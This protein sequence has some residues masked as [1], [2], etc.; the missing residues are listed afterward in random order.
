MDIY[1][2]FLYRMHK[3]G[4]DTGLVVLMQV[5]DFY[6]TYDKSAGRCQAVLGLKLHEQVKPDKTKHFITGFPKHALNDYVPKLVAVGCRVVVLDK[7]CNETVFTKDGDGISF[8][9]TKSNNSSN[10]NSKTTTT[11]ATKNF[12]KIQVN[13][14]YM[15]NQEM[16]SLVEMTLLRQRISID[17]GKSVHEWK[18]ADTDQVLKTEYVPDEMGVMPICYNTPEDFEKGKSMTIEELFYTHNEEGLC[19]DL[20]EHRRYVRSDEKGAFIWAF[21]NGKAEKWYFADHIDTITIEGCKSTADA[22]IPEA[23]YNAEEVYQYNDYTEVK[24]DG[25]KVQHEGV[26]N[27]LMLDDDQK[28]LADKLQAVIDECNE[29]GMCI[30]FNTADYTLNT[31]NVR[32]VERL[33]Y[34]PNV[35]EDTEKAYPFADDRVG[36]S[37]R[38][39]TDL[40]TEDSCIQFV[41]KK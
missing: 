29:K 8:T 4:N 24:A 2:E 35:D 7:E 6:E 41:I 30:Y 20:V 39:V 12:Q 10:N 33:E 32:R 27:R 37:F 25:T 36:R 22:E 28:V 13:R 14:V 5:G 11:M 19:N 34:D 38:N 31:V 26:Y 18:V 3:H 21:V 16:Q 15:Y 40:N 23:Y 9:T 17:T 1:N